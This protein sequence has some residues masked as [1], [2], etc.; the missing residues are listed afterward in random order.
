LAMSTS[1]PSWAMTSRRQAVH[2]LLITR[3]IPLDMAWTWAMAESLKRGLD[4]PAC[5]R[6]CSMYALVSFSS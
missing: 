4:A 3:G 6:T 2:K 1:C 5:L